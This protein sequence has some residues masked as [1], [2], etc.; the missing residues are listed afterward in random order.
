MHAHRAM[1]LLQQLSWKQERP[2][3]RVQ[4]TCRVKEGRVRAVDEGREH[5]CA[6]GQ[7]QTPDGG[8]PFRIA[9]HPAR[10]LEVGD[11]PSGEHHQRSSLL[12]PQMCGAQP[13]L[14][15]PGGCAAVEGVDEEAQFGELGNSRQQIVGEDADVRASAAEHPGEGEAVEQAV[16]VV[17][18]YD[19]RTVVRNSRDICGRDQ[20]RD[21]Q[22]LERAPFE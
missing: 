3:E 5:A 1:A 11:L 14:A 17:R 12:Q 20:R 21:I 18:R 16:R 6:G 10:G 9:V 7:R 4:P 22:R 13:G 15:A 2:Q 19:E 8:P